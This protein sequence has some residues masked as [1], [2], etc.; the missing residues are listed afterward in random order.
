METFPVATLLYRVGRM[1]FRRRWY[2]ALMW[3]GV[4]A[5]VGFGA[6]KAP[7]AADDGFSIPGTESQQ[8]SDLMQ[9]HFPGTTATGAYARIV[10]VAP[11]GHKITASG[12]EAAVEKAVAEVAAGPQV[13]GA[14]NPFQANAVSKDGTTAYATVSYKVAANDLTGASKSTLE[15]AVK[16]ARSAGLTVEV[17][18][19]ALAAQPAAGG[20]TEGIGIVIAALVLLVTF[21]SLAAAGLPLMTAIMSVGVG[22]AA[23]TALRGVFHL[24]STTGTLA[25]MLGLAV[26]IDYAVF[27]VSRFREER[28]KGHEP[29][30][31][32]AP[33]GPRCVRGPDRRHRAGRSL[34]GRHPD[35][36]QDGPGRRGDGRGRR[37][38]CAD[39]GARAARPV[40]ACRAAARRPPGEEDQGRGPPQWRHPVG[41]AGAAL[42]RARAADL[43]PRPRSAR[44]ARD[45]AA[46]G[47][48]GRR[49]QAHLDHRTPCL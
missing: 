27:I 29:Q 38:R 46:P 26:G 36:D 1:A 23:I 14:A 48:S 9:Q 20:A 16:Q 8:A 39:P 7:A 40:P 43:R 31:A 4:L 32:S 33:P 15:D 35:A 11:S 18:G 22:V 10:F 45:G 47:H 44:P 24:T 19:T 30:V 13:A 34:G 37:V 6:A 12:S 17:G 41:P 28:A 49:V 3:V 5:A 21:G 2:V 25:I 42:P